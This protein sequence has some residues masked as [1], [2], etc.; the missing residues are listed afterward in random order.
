MSNSEIQ[1]LAIGRPRKPALA[2]LY[3]SAILLALI[4][5]CPPVTAQDL[6]IYP[7]KGQSANQQKRDR[8]E[9]HLW[10]V[11]QTGFDPSRVNPPPSTITTTTEQGR[12]IGSGAPARGA[13]RGAAVGAV[14]GAIGGNAGKGAAIGAASGALIG[15]MRHR[16]ATRP[17][18]ITQT[19]PAYSEYKSKQNRYE[20]A[21]KA[22]LSGRGYG[23]E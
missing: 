11:D 10:A 13:A 2:M 20:K 7:A 3:V 16:D 22:C 5:L 15:G 12:A 1:V 21:M 8:A 4:C 6:M 9:C 18:T 19:N 17:Q 14:G 23:V